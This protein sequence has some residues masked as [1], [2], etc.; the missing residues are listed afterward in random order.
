MVTDAEVG[1]T[2][3]ERDETHAIRPV[4]GQDTSMPTKEPQQATDDDGRMTPLRKT[5]M[6]TPG[7]MPDKIGG[8]RCPMKRLRSA[9]TKRRPEKDPP[10]CET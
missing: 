6:T 5:T 7:T 2:V 3:E 9:A 4:E 10:H 8:K 1:S